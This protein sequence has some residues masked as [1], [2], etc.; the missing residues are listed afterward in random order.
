MDSQIFLC[1]LLT[2]SEVNH[3]LNGTITQNQHPIQKMFDASLTQLAS[4]QIWN[5]T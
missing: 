2:K 3:E 5:P 4:I 1:R